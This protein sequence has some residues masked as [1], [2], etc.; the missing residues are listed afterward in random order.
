MRNEYAHVNLLG[1]AR[2]AE[3]AGNS[4]EAKQFYTKPR[5]IASNASPVLLRNS[6]P[7]RGVA[8][9]RVI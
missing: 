9:K 8:G 3:V 4:A 1:A 5:Q 2:S 7:V 6:K